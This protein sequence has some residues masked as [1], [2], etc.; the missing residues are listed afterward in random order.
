MVG[1]VTLIPEWWAGIMSSGWYCLRKHLNMQFKHLNKQF[2]VFRHIKKMI[3]EY[4]FRLSI[5]YLD[6]VFSHFRTTAYR[7]HRGHTLIIKLV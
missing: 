7:L 1:T 6:F 4:Q 3:D 2:T 5:S